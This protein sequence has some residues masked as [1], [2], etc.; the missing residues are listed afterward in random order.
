MTLRLD[1]RESKVKIARAREHLVSLNKELA[2]LREGHLYVPRYSPIDDDGWC[3]VSVLQQRFS[4]TLFGVYAG[5]FYHNL[6]CAYD[7]IVTALVDASSAT[8]T[9]R[10]QFPI[11]ADIGEY[12]RRVGEPGSLPK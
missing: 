9:T 7:Y 11:C 4:D 3:T 6:R 1:L 8:L 5:E 12:R 10:H 2:T